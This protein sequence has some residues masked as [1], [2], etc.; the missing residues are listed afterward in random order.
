MTLGGRDFIQTLTEQCRVNRQLFACPCMQ[1]AP[2]N[3]LPLQ[4][5]LLHMQQPPQ[6]H[7]KTVQECAKK[8]QI[9]REIHDVNYEKFV[10]N[11]P[12]PVDF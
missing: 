4:T 5:T 12:M 11:K 3:N 6:N 10:F 1:V 7:Q 2:G 9:A 8:S